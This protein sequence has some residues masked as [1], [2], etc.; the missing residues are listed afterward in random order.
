MDESLEADGIRG[1]QGEPRHLVTLRLR[2]NEKLRRD[3]E[4]LANDRDRKIGEIRREESSS[5]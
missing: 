3:K 1:R 2:L 4:R 5:P